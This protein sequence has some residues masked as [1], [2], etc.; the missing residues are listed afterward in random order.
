[1]H[2]VYEVAAVRAAEDALMQ[3]LPP[4]ALMQRAARGLATECA[5]V[6]GRP[7]GAQ[8]ILLVGAGNNGGDALFAGAELAGRGARV[9]ALLLNPHNA[10]GDAM[11]AFRRA[12][13]RVAEAASDAMAGADLVV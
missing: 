6:L 3:R 10:H 5:V 4:G 13:G 11:A 1:M 8:V 2:G 12:G 9:T 7:Y